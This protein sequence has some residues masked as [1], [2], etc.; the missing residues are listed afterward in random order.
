MAKHDSDRKVLEFSWKTM[1]CVSLCFQASSI[2]FIKS[3]QAL[4]AEDRRS[5]LDRLTIECINLRR[6]VT[7]EILRDG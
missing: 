2:I 5:R 6:N 1:L 7:E 4:N 3:I